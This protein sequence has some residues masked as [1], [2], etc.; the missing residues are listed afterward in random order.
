MPRVRLIVLAVYIVSF[1]LFGLFPVQEK[2][3]GQPP[4][5]RTNGGEL[6]AI[7]IGLRNAFNKKFPETLPEVKHRLPKATA[8][9]FDWC[10]FRKDVYIHQQ[11]H[12][13]TCWTHA[14]VAS[15]EWNWALRNTPEHAPV[16]SPQPI[17]DRTQH[18][19]GNT[20][21]SAMG[22]LLNYGAASLKDYPYSG[23]PAKLKDNIRTPFRV[24]AWNRIS[25][26]VPEVEQLKKALLEHGPIPAGVFT[27]PAF[28]KYR[29]GVF[30]EHLQT[31]TQGKSINHFVLIVGWDDKKGKGCWKI[32][33]S[34]GEKWGESGFMWI[35]YGSH[36]I[37][38]NALWLKPQST[39]YVLPRNAQTLVSEKAAPFP[40]WPGA[41][42]IDLPR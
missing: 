18:P 15:L 28:H 17:L 3:R 33:N 30:A 16:L 22:I 7:D 2:V 35:E 21:E 42:E 27:T 12:F 8:A 11:G 13:G 34:W 26:K 1:S 6:L 14:P 40:H 37:G 32:Q 19:G 9:A 31:N 36:N 24:I 39:H 20:E 29:G 23:K 10:H 41:K 38:H 4:T 25:S 5:P